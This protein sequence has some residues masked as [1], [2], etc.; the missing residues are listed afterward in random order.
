MFELSGSSFGPHGCFKVIKASDEVESVTVTS[1][2]SEIFLLANF[3]RHSPILKLIIQAF[4]NQVSIYGDAGHFFI[5]LCASLILNGLDLISQGIERSVCC[6]VYQNLLHKLNLILEDP[7]C[8]LKAAV[9]IK[10]HGNDPTYCQEYAFN[11]KRHKD[12]V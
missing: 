4:K 10:E 11:K 12:V 1:I 5:Q 7:K 8:S 9:S 3:T 6:S 2:S